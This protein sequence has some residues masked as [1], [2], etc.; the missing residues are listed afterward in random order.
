MRPEES[1]S[2]ENDTPKETLPETTEPST[3]S[4]NNI[5]VSNVDQEGDTSPTEARPFSD[6]NDSNPP[7]VAASPAFSPVKKSNK[8]PLLIGIGVAV[9][10]VL[11]GGYAA[12]AMWWNAPDK[13]VDDALAS[14]MMANSGTAKG[15]LETIQEGGAT[16][17]LAFDSKAAGEKSSSVLGLDVK[18]DGQ[19]VNLGGE[20]VTDKGSYYIKL[21]DVKKA[22]TKLWGESE[23]LAMFDTLISKIDNKWVVVTADDVKRFTGDEG[24]SDK[25]LTC[26]Q[27]VLGD[28]RT[29]KTY[30][31]ELSD[32]YQ[33]NRFIL[34]KE[35]K[36][37]ESIDGRQS[38]H[39]VLSFD[40]AKS[41]SFG[42][43]LKNTSVFK[44]VDDCVADD[45]AKSTDNAEKDASKSEA[46]TVELWVD[47]WSHKPTRL[48]IS[49]NSADS[50]K[51]VID[52]VFHLDAKV[53]I[54]TPKADTTV[55]DLETEINNLT[56]GFAPTPS[57]FGT[58]PTDEL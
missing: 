55:K 30:Q 14:V 2:T 21:S 52:S 26:V 5:A 56:S 42:E 41:K 35:S 31:K 8:K 12:Y 16:V 38:N 58:M 49:S 48:K 50:G 54:D 29:N 1:P 13:V 32:A 23:A 28:I 25:E 11:V 6:F 47:T 10:A 17:K 57:E 43:A 39:Y 9:L 46:P 33:K 45:L 24:V 4:Q 53:S 18:S 37:T 20:V 40:E 27:D 7:A 3:E 36:G 34:V 19:S 44:A 51:V 15:S 22:L